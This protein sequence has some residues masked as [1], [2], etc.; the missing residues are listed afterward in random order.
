MEIQKSLG[1][2]LY[3][4]RLGEADMCARIYTRESGKRCFVFK[5]LRKSKTR[6]HAATEPGTLL[7]LVYYQHEEREYQVVNE[8]RIEAHCGALREDLERIAHLYFLLEMVDRTSA[9][10]DPHPQLYALL[11]GALEELGRTDYTAHLSVFF[12]IHLL[13]RLGV[14]PDLSRCRMCGAREF[15]SF[16]FDRGEL[17][18][19]CGTCARESRGLK[20]VKSARL[21]DYLRAT[22]GSRFSATDHS[23]FQREDALHL[24]FHLVLF[25]ESYFHVEIKS[26]GMLFDQK[27]A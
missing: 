22:L 24:L 26:K 8:F 12:C 14:L 25:T 5:G 6:P 7:N 13:R 11:K 17:F 4:R 18:A 9:P 21:G 16:G 20:I 19:V 10:N 2:V 15:Q 1:I 3:S 23:I 27:I